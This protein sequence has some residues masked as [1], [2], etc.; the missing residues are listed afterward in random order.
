MTNDESQLHSQ[1]HK[2]SSPGAILSQARVAAGMTYDDVAKELYMT[3]TKIKALESDDYAH[4]NSETFVRGYL[5][6]YANLLKLDPLV[7]IAAFE[8]K[9]NEENALSTPSQPP[10]VSAN[11]NKSAW[12]FLIGIGAILVI[13]WLISVWFF[14]NRADDKYSMSTSSTDLNLTKVQSNTTASSSLSRVMAQEPVIPSLVAS[15]AAVVKGV[16]ALRSQTSS[17][18]SSR[19]YAQN[20]GELKSSDLKMS[21]IVTAIDDSVAGLSLKKIAKTTLDEIKFNFRD[22][23]WL[24]VSDSRGDVLA[25]ELQAAGSKLTLVGKAPFDV[26]LGN[27]DAVEIFLNGKS[28]RV[29]PLP[30]TNVLMLKVAE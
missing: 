8:R 27:S 14:N 24:E 4:L 1:L 7:V 11:P 5:R 13:L 17:A 16:S 12:N 29:V 26:K 10:A 21:G 18:S 25:T 28:I 2:K 19:S 22:E 23:S 15:T 6:T 3:V 20:A 30:G 9:L